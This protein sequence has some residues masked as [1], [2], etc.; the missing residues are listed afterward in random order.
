ML[1]F[2]ELPL[3]HLFCHLDGTTSGPSTFTGAIGKA[4][5]N[6]NKL[7]VVTYVSILEPDFPDIGN[8]VL[9][10]L[11]TDQKYLY[12]I[13]MAIRSGNC[14]ADLA[15][16]EPG[17]M[18]HARWLTMANR[19]CRLYIA[20]E[21]PSRTLSD[22]VTFIV[23]VYAPTWFDIKRRP[24]CMEGAK[25]LHRYILRSRYLAPELRNNVDACVQRNAFFAHH[26]AVLLA[27]I[28]DSDAVIRELGSRRIVNARRSHI[29]DT[30][31]T[32][33]PPQLNFNACNYYNMVD[34]SHEYCAPTTTF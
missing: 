30:I 14:A 31:R 2:N 15:Q 23:R 8:D 17:K 16:R 13:C 7:P 18:S 29:A 4:L 22:I 5:A 34:W 27:M 12:E 26:E 24:S 21:S 9:I 28:N 32:F 19:V 10:D 1:H 11:S 20:T 25:H 33:K 6:C 3:R